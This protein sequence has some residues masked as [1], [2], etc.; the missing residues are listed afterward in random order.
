[1]DDDGLL[2]VI[3]EEV[4]AFF[5]KQSTS[6]SD[7]KGA[8]AVRSW[9]KALGKL[10][11]ANLAVISIPGAYAAL[12][13]DRALDEGMNV[14]MFSDNVTLE[15]EIKLK[16]KAHEKG[17]AVMGPD[18][19]TGIIQGVP[20]A[21]TNHVA[22]GPIGIIGASGTGI[23]ELTTI[24]DRLGEGVKNAIGTGG[25]D[26][27]TEVGGI[28][29]MDMIEAMEKDDTVK[30]LIIISKPP[31][32]AVRDRI[33]DR[34]S[35]F[36]KPVVTLFLG[37]KPEYHEENFYHAYTLDEAAR[38]AVGLVR[39]QDI[40]EGSVEADSSSF[41]AAEEKKT[42]KAYYSGGTLAGEAAMLI[43][44]A[45]NLK[46]PPQKAEG[47]MLK[48]DG[49]IVVD[50]GD[51]VYTQGKPHPM[52]DPAKRIEC[53]QEAIDDE[54]TGVI[55]LDIMLGYGSHED[56][57]GALLPAIIRLRDKARE[58]GRKLFFVATVCGTRRD[59]QGYD[60][61][62]ETLK[63]AGVIVCEN[64]KL[65]VHTAIRAIGLDFEE[66]VKE[67]RPKTTARIQ[68]TE[69]S[70]KLL[71]LLSQKPRVIN[72]GLKSFAEV[73]EAF[74]CDVV[75][76]DWAPPAGGNVEL[77]KV[78]NF[79][80]SCREMDIDEAN[81]S[82][83]A[84]V[85][86][87]QPVIKDVVPAKSV[88]KELNE[89]KVILH[90]G[91]P[92]RFENMPDPVQGSCVGA[93]LF[94]GWAATEEE[95]RKILAS[96]E[97]TFI[98]CHHV[99]AVGPMGGITSANMPVFVVE[100]QT[101]GNE[102]YCTMNEGIGKVLRF[103]AYSK[104]VVDR[105][106]WMKDV[107]GPTLGRA[108]RSIGGLNVNPLVAKAIAMGD[109]FHQRNIAASLAFLKEVSPVITKMDMDEKDR[110]DVIK[111]LADTDQFFLNI[112]MATGKAV[113]DAARQVTD[114]TIVT[115]MCRNGVEFGIRISGMGDE[116][117]T[118]PVNTPQGLYFTGY[119]GE[120]AC[121]DMGD[122]A[123][124]ETFGV[125]GMAMIA[126]PAVTRFVGAGGYEDA[127]LTSTEMTEI[128]I[129]RNPNFIIP[130]WN[131]QGTSL[132]IDARLVVEKGITPVINTGI[133]HK[134]AGYGQIGAGTVHPPIACFE[135]AIAAYA[136]K[137]GFSL[138]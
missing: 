20:I 21:F 133:A 80:R 72:V 57:A 59:F 63:E 87:S 128:T 112:M 101:D 129:D 96:G 12:E 93:A 1:M 104:E 98:P 3:M 121:P 109:E 85:V 6:E 13:A 45:L 2:D 125:G 64:N 73:I 23:Q 120:D 76:Y 51:D 118:A 14:F 7:K 44:D 34:L 91:P 136:K 135:K 67:I 54:S 52:I 35:N 99:K 16:K 138:D 78:L 95:A 117:F 60:K 40:A 77:I 36:K 65:A 97:V 25:R 28:T 42:I 53:M 38:L 126:A 114:G 37:E 70:E 49:H 69:A 18:C 116:W 79:L 71:E 29:M 83:I 134:V 19:G 56:M 50:L 82:V 39:G 43:K 30:V 47:F 48:T 137:L 62:V 5:K 27:S 11:D 88:I 33:S 32:K 105:L 81:R 75:Q 86:A 66:P 31:A 46:V 24:I 68:K 110:Y 115:A 113:M 132:G 74:G 108:I 92:I 9:D 123:I 22:P 107:L 131:F 15:D 17:L 122:S 103:G 84:K 58:E 61:A 55:L 26:L 4:E 89:G 102:A 10:A 111:F 90:A 124:T 119:D 100:N 94:E 130:N 41:F 8:E 106:L 127:L